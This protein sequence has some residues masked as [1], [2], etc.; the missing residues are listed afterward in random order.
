MSVSPRR[1][2]GFDATANELSHFMTLALRFLLSPATTQRAEQ[3][4]I[5]PYVYWFSHQRSNDA[6][7]RPV[8]FPDAVPR[9]GE[10]LHLVEGDFLAHRATYDVVATLF[11]IDTS[12][13][14]IAT[15]EHIFELLRPGGMWINLGPL[16]WPGGGQA[17]V[18]LSLDEVLRLAKMIGFEIEGE[19]G[20]PLE[21]E[22]LRRRGVRCEYTGDRRAMMKY[23]YDAEFWVARKPA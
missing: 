12:L 19:D 14:V 22:A 23:M 10:R 15:L 8:A 5:Y 17:R 16:L 4:T 21:A 3:H 20:S 6:L 1:L 9:L 18:E 7:F 11:F 13:N 2:V